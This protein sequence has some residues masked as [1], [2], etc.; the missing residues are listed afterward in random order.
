MFVCMSYVRKIRALNGVCV[1]PLGGGGVQQKWERHKTPKRRERE[2][3][4]I[5]DLKVGPRLLNKRRKEKQS[6]TN[7]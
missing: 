7:K 5:V 4:G 2:R 3:E 6:N 1:L